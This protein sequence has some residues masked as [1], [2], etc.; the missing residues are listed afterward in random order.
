MA[1]P[2]MSTTALPTP[3][4]AGANINV[5]GFTLTNTGTADT[6]G[7]VFTFELAGANINR[8]S[9]AGMDANGFSGMTVTGYGTPTAVLTLPPNFFGRNAAA[10]GGTMSVPVALTLETSSSTPTTL[11]TTIVASNGGPASEQTFTV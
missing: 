7:I 4:R 8:I 2:D 3:A 5:P 6:I 10:G 1:L 11:D 9:A